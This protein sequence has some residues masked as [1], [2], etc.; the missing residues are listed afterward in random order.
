MVDRTEML[1]DRASRK[2][3]RWSSLVKDT[4]LS[5]KGTRVRIPHGPQGGKSWDKPDALIGI[6]SGR[7]VPRD[8][9]R[10]GGARVAYWPARSEIEDARASP[11]LQRKRKMAIRLRKV[12]DTW[13]ALCAVESDP[14]EGDIYLDDSI[15]YALA[16]KFAR[17]HDVDWE[18]ERVNALM[19]SQKVRDAREEF[20]KWDKTRA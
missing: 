17:E 19:D 15:H 4:C 5:S 14:K 20:E 10:G 1:A 18:D 3:A 11:P 13:V 12:D 9:L 2:K 16:C 6:H 7:G 8:A